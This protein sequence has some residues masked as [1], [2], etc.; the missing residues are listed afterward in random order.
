MAAYQFHCDASMW[1]ACRCLGSADGRTALELAC[2]KGHQGV[3]EMLLAAGADAN[4]QVRRGLLLFSHN[5]VVLIYA[6]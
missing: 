2:V 5:L 6:S 4:L 3:A 1:T